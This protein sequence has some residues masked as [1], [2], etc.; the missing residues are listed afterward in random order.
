M[1][2]KHIKIYGGFI[3][4]ACSQKLPAENVIK[5]EIFFY[6]IWCYFVARFFNLNVDRVHLKCN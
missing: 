5:F 1:K 4:F 3:L 6:N 2:Y